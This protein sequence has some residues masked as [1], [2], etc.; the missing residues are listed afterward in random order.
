[1]RSRA[2]VDRCPIAC[3]NGTVIVDTHAHIC[4]TAFDVDRAVVLERARAAGV[5]AIVAV[6]EGA[7]DI[8]RNLQLAAEHP[9]LRPAGGLHPTRADRAEAAQAVAAI[10]AAV[11]RL[12]AIGEVG[13]D[14]W[15][16]R[17]EAARRLQA[18]VL[19]I[20]AAL[21]AE[22]DL[23]LNVHSRSA[24]RQAIDALLSAGARRVQMH[25]FDGKA[26]TALPAVEAGFFFSIP[27]SLVRSRQKQKLVERLPLGCLLLETDSPVLAPAAGQ[28]N[29]PAN[30]LAVVEAIA[31]IKGI[32]PQAVIDAAAENTQRLY[33]PAVCG[34]PS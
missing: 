7:A 14:Y 9:I 17:D 29:E 13:L 33:G 19:A 21:A 20:F 12:A 11:P 18:D 32:A 28:R 24:G 2:G 23:P 16:A 5:E 15:V 22:L 34:H 31:S 3:E 25:A 27:P 6:S 10:R 8:E 26:S 1:M 4:D 30:V